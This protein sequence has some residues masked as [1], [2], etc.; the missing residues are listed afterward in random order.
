[1]VTE[2]AETG[3]L[4]STLSDPDAPF[5]F[6]P[7]GSH[8]V[9]FVDLDAERTAEH[10]SQPAP[11]AA[12]LIG[13]DK[14]GAVPEGLGQTFDILLT[15][16]RH[17]PREWVSVPESQIDA[18]VA[19]LLSICRANPFAASI[20]VQV[21]RLGVTLGFQDALILESLGYSTLLAGSDFRR[22]RQMNP[23]RSQKG[24][25]CAVTMVHRDA[26]TLSITLNRPRAHNAMN[27]QM[28][29]E[30]VNAL[31]I[32]AAD[33]K[34]RN[35]VLDGNG[36][37][38]SSGGDLDEFGTAQDQGLAHA[39]RVGRSAAGL[40]HRCT[41]RTTA[42][43]HG[44]CLGAG[45]EIS[46]AAGQVIADETMSAGLPEISIGLIPGA[47]GTVTLPRRIGRHRTCYL[48]LSGAR[49]TLD[50]ALEWGLVDERR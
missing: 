36:A 49:L 34:I 22:W 44:A 6:S 28:R 41:D 14:V 48:G 15:T 16:A 8:P 27:A 24:E 2:G 13:I 25:E 4:P 38:F 45:I 10:R 1:M 9:I 37:S 30:L 46:A 31:Q 12:I 17:P 35:I 47:G 26:D 39:V 18:T 3:L 50:Q 11:P 19:E 32:A 23:P 7:A 43:L 21:L 42:L 40:I 20:F 33:P 5:L 29:D